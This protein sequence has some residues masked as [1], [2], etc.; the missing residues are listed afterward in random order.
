VQFTVYGYI[1]IYIYKACFTIYS[2]VSEIHLLVNILTT[3]S[4]VKNCQDRIVDMNIKSIIKDSQCTYNR[5]FRRV[6][7]TIVAVG[8]Q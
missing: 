3:L 4:S 2:I 8:R 6:R 5:M 7:V 1:Y